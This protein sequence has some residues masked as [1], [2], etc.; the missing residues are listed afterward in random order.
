MLDVCLALSVEVW[1]QGWA[2]RLSREW[3]EC[4]CT[5]YLLHTLSKERRRI[6]GLTCR[7]W[8][9]SSMATPFFGSSMETT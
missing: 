9:S 4:S 8:T 3:V 1:H 6:S 2:M 7:G 5:V